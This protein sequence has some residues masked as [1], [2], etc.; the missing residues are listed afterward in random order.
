MNG[1]QDLFGHEEKETLSQLRE[2]LQNDL[3]IIELAKVECQRVPGKTEDKIEQLERAVKVVSVRIKD[4]R[5]LFLKQQMALNKFMKEGG[6]DW[7]KSK[8]VYA[9]SS[10]QAQMFLIRNVV[11]KL[12]DSNSS[13]LLLGSLIN[14]TSQLFSENQSIDI[15]SQR[16]MFSLKEVEDIP[17][18][19]LNELRFIKQRSPQWFDARKQL[20]L[21]GSTI[22][23]GLGL[24]SL[25]LQRRHFDKVVKNIEIAEVISE[26]TAKRMEHGTV[27][28]IHA[29]ATLTTK[30]L[31]LYYPN[32][33]YIEEGAHVINSNG[34]PLILVSPDGSLGKMNMDG[35]DIPTPVVACEFKCPSPSDFRTPVHYDMP[36]RYI[37]QVLSEMA[38]MNVEEL[39]YLCWTDESSTVFRVH[40]D[41]DT[42]K[43]IT[44]EAQ[45][46]YLKETPKCPTRLSAESK[47][48]KERLHIFR[49]NNCEFICEVA[50]CKG[51]R[52]GC[53]YLVDGSPYVY[54]TCNTEERNNLTVDEMDSI[55]SSINTCINEAYQIC[56]KKATEVIVWILAD[57]D[58]IFNPDVPY[59]IPIAYAMKGYSLGTKPMREMHE[60]VLRMCH[61]KQINVVASCFDSQWAKLSTRDKNDK[62]LTIM[63][64]QRDVY[65]EASKLTRDA[66]VKKLLSESILP[67][68]QIFSITEKT[69]EGLKVSSPMLKRITLSLRHK[70]KQKKR[71]SVV[72]NLDSDNVSCLPD[73]ALETLI[74][75]D[76]HTMFPDRIDVEEETTSE[77]TVGDNDDEDNDM[78][79]VADQTKN[80]KP[81][82]PRQ[83]QPSSIH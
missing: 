25:K 62:P 76:N 80:D 24:D 46:V 54:P 64:L 58:R 53:S 28:E 65:S 44:E 63:Q 5:M 75:E 47:V 43:L 41:T 35:I 61:E 17:E 77:N 70:L 22:F 14:G 72:Q 59:A 23:G 33:A 66:I 60:D 2:R 40:F 11:K 9:I 34:T 36:I 68:E 48:I 1:D 51:E 82:P 81:V 4:L 39:I 74:V 16:N 13:L 26:D 79:E 21:T 38:S 37:P 3:N 67:A 6:K 52:I 78:N 71:S 10:V 15:F 42:W 50:S 27:S 45:N 12:L 19:L 7:K 8:Y 32:L 69:E 55:F 73:E 57:T 18:G 31:P 30:V 49:E 83:L 20:K 29:I 56:R